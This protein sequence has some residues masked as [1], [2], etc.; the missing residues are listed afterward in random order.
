MFRLRFVRLVDQRVV[1]FQQRVGLRVSYS[2]SL[3]MPSVISA[4][5]GVFRLI[6]A[7]KRTCS[8]ATSPGGVRSSCSDALGHAGGGDTARLGA[9]PIGRPRSPGRALVAAPDPMA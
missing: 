9:S 5:R 6:V 8:P 3:G 7:G 2:A 1:G 4:G